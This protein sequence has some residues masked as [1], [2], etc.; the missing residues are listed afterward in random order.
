MPFYDELNSLLIQWR[1]RAP[2][3]VFPDFDYQHELGPHTLIFLESPGP[4][5]KKGRRQVSVNNQDDTARELKR[6]VSTAFDENERRRILLWNAIPWHLEGAPHKKDIN[7]SKSLHDELLT[8]VRPELQFVV[9]LGASARGLLPIL[10]PR[11]GHAHIYGG[12]HTGRK[13]QHMNGLR[14]ENIDL[15]AKIKRLKDIT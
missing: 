1:H 9:L 7:E 6:L 5:T 3:K 8:L 14:Q 13:A 10:S 15:F 2:G 11:V 12:H 4:Q